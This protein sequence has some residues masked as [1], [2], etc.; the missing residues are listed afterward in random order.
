MR[1]NGA[2]S[3]AGPNMEHHNIS[4]SKS[5]NVPA[6][7]GNTSLVIECILMVALRLR[8][9]HRMRNVTVLSSTSSFPKGEL[10]GQ[11]S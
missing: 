9:S 8:I 3:G 5:L 1:G 11:V 4:E 6:T 10:N 2:Y 7:V